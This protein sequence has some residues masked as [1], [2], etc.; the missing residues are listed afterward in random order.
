MDLSCGEV[1]T[2]CWKYFVSV[3]LVPLLRLSTGLLE[4]PPAEIVDQAGLLGE[5]YELR[6][7]HHT[8]L[9]MIPSRQSL[10]ADDL[11]AIEQHL[12]LIVDREFVALDCVPEITL[13]TQ[14]LAGR[15]IHLQVEHPVTDRASSLRPV[16]RDIRIAQEIVRTLLTRRAEGYADA[17]TQMNVLFSDLYWRS[18]A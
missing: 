13:Q 2:H 5:G 3:F 18:Q 9:R 12:R 8:T 10:E 16:H 7:G 1:H 11:A 14:A 6:R 4:H 17:G 15:G